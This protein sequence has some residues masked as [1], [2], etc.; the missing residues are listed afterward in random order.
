MIKAPK[1]CGVDN[2]F[3]MVKKVETDE[4]KRE[5]KSVQV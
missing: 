5:D 3:V 4:K 2:A 1:R